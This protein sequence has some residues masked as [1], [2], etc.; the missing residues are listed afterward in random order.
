MAEFLFLL[1]SKLDQSSNVQQG[2][3]PTLLSEDRKAPL[4][5]WFFV[6]VVCDMSLTQQ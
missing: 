4:D 6:V 2:P 1:M 3:S 5:Q